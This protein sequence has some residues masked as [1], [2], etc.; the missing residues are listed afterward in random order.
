VAGH[1][2]QRGQHG[3]GVRPADHVQVVDQA[4]LLAQPQ[5]LGQE[6]EVHPGPLGRLGQVRE[7]AELDVAA[8]PRVA[9][10]GGVVDAGEVRG[11]VH[12]LERLGHGSCSLSWLGPAQA[13]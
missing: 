5:P 12:L 8:R 10:H 3:E 2:G 13:A 6:Q 1:R 7:R 9:P 4:V 11:E